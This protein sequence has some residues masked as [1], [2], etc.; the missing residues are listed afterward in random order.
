MLMLTVGSEL[1]CYPI[2]RKGIPLCK[3]AIWKFEVPKVK[4]NDVRTNDIS[5]FIM[6]GNLIVCGNRYEIV[7]TQDSISFDYSLLL[8]KC[9][10]RILNF[11]FNKITQLA[12]NKVIKILN[13]N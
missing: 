9:C 13:G 7:S 11:I 5:R 4:R 8:K 12:K 10:V 1:R 3:N 6:S 2:D